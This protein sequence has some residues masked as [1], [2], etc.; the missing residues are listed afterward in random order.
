MYTFIRLTK[1]SVIADQKNA[2]DWQTNKVTKQKVNNVTFVALYLD[3]TLR[4]SLIK[5]IYTRGKRI[6]RG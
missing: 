1:H 3:G 6:L 2:K 4:F 5:N